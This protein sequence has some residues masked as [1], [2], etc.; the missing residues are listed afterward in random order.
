MSGFTLRNKIEEAKA[1]YLKRDRKLDWQWT[2]EGLHMQ[3]WTIIA[4]SVR[5]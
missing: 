5:F 4:A 1:I 3:S 2:D